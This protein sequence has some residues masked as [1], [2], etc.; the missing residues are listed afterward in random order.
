VSLWFVLVSMLAAV[1]PARLAV[2]MGDT[3]SRDRT[4]LLGLGAL[5][6]TVVVVVLGLFGDTLL[7]ALEVTD[8]TW[9]IAAGAVAVLSG[10]RHLAIRPAKPIPRVSVPAHAIAPIAFP[11]LLVPEIVVLAVLYGT[12][13]S[14]GRLVFGAV[15]GFG[16][17]AVWGRIEDGAVTRGMVRVFAA[18]LVVAGIVLIVAGIRDI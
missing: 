6:S 3:A 8:E 5:M 1:N 2:L 7:D 10:A 12:T 11:G 4:R 13:E 16:A 15:V 18:L 9:R 14:V 17:A